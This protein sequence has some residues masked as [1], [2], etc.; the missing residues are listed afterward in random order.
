MMQITKR[1]RWLAIGLTVAVALWALYALAIRPACD[2]IRVLERVVPE[3]QA[4]LQDLQA[5]IAQ[6]TALRDEFAQARDADGGAGARFR[7]HAVPGGHD[8]P[9][10]ARPPCRHHESGHR[11]APTGLLRNRRDHRAARYFPEGV[12]L[13]PHRCREFCIPGTDR[14]S[15][16]S[17]QTRNT[18]PSSTRP[19]RFTAPSWARRRWLPKRRHNLLSSLRTTPPRACLRP[20]LRAVPTPRK[21]VKNLVKIFAQRVLLFVNASIR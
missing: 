8:R 21:S 19:W 11:P 4:Q 12:G 2:R 1:E 10:Q 3:R 18:R 6:Y 20:E 16:T 14:H 17:A 13:F 5:K 9:A 15:G 7:H